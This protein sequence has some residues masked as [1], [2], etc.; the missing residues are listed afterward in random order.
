MSVRSVYGQPVT[1]PLV[2]I[3]RIAQ[4]LSTAGCLTPARLATASGNDFALLSQLVTNLERFSGDLR[5]N[6]ER[7]VEAAEMLPTVRAAVALA[8]DGS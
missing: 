1:P 4:Q 2:Q 5:G 7:E 6:W 3:D 8:L